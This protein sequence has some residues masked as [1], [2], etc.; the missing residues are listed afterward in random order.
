M[1][2][3]TRAVLL[4]RLKLD[5]R[6]FYRDVKLLREVGILVELEKGK[7]TLK[8]DV[9]EAI[10]CLPFPDPHSH[11]ARPCNWPGAGASFTGS[12]RG[13]SSSE[14]SQARHEGRAAQS[15]NCRRTR[16]TTMTS[17]ARTISQ[18]EGFSLR[19]A[20]AARIS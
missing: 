16:A 17:S 10:E 7:Y 3:Q 20:R 4:Q 5:V 8:G 12:S 14:I 9:E 11:S 18:P 19:K 15:R 2:N 1:R 13:C 6:G